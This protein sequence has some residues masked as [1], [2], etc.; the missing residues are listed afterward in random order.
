MSHFAGPRV[1]DDPARV[2]VVDTNLAP[3][4]PTAHAGVWMKTLERFNDPRKG[5]ETALVKFDPGAGLPEEVLDHRMEIFV[6]SGTYR[7]GHGEYSE[8]T[9]IRNLPGFRHRPASAAGCVIYWKRRV[10]IYPDEAGWPRLVIDAKTAQ[11]LEFPHRGAD[12]LHLYRDP[13]GLETARIGHVHTKRRI[14]S[15]DHSIGE[16]TFVLKGCLTDQYQPYEEGVWFRMPCGVPH[17][18]FTGDRRCMMLIR[19]GD[20]VW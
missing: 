14:P 20:M 1:N 19:E 12:V 15:H 2:A 17:A 10:P 5:R 4:E 16:E 8:R 18:P 13:N 9:F 3:W 6:V 7:D 11:W